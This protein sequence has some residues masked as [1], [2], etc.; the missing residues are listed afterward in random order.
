MYLELES[1]APDAR[2]AWDRIYEWEWK[3]DKN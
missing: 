3:A 2:H 1:N